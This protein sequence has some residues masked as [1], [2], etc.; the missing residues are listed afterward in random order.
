MHFPFAVPLLLNLVNGSVPVTHYSDYVSEREA[1]I[2]RV[3]RPHLQNILNVEDETPLILHVNVLLDHT[4]TKLTLSTLSK[5]CS[6]REWVEVK[7]KGINLLAMDPKVHPHL[8]QHLGTILS[9]TTDHV[10][11]TD[12]SML[13]RIT[14]F[15]GSPSSLWLH[16]QVLCP[17]PVP[18]NCR[19]LLYVTSDPSDSLATTLTKLTIWPRS[20]RALCLMLVSRQVI[21]EDLSKALDL[22]LERVFSS[23]EF[24]QLSR[25]GILTE[26]NLGSLQKCSVLRV[27]SVS[28]NIQQPE[29]LFSVVSGLPCL[30]YLHLHG[31]NNML[32]PL[33]SLYNGLCDGFRSL[34]HLH[35]E[36]GHRFPYF[37][38]DMADK[39]FAVPGPTLPPTS[40]PLLLEDESG[41]K[42]LSDEIVVEWLSSVRPDVCFKVW[43]MQRKRLRAPELHQAVAMD[44]AMYNYSKYE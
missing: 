21:S 39:T 36:C 6:L 28:N 9:P 17:I 25:W 37:D 38:L 2:L 24:L 29:S 3:W 19:D 26:H 44:I 15:V 13:R 12:P 4:T 30:E 7:L 14:H 31:G 34:C 23:I 1:R 5:V 27:L 33:L 40:V 8:Y 42:T 41:V 32:S 10:Y 20:L 18:L 16:S 43:S 35:F 22:L 11:L